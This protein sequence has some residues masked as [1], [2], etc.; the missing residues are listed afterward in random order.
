MTV[1]NKE[2]IAFNY[3]ISSLFRV[4]VWFFF[5]N[6]RV[7]VKSHLGQFASCKFIKLSRVFSQFMKC[8]NAVNNHIGLRSR[9]SVGR[10]FNDDGVSIYFC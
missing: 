10:R 5:F 8:M 7:F 9:R 1:V 3:L 4:L 2:S 6:L